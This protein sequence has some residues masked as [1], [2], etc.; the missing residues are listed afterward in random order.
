MYA[1]G[2]STVSLVQQYG[3]LGRCLRAKVPLNLKHDVA[4]GSLQKFAGGDAVAPL[5]NDPDGDELDEAWNPRNKALADHKFKADISTWGYQDQIGAAATILC[6]T[7][8]R[9]MA[10]W[11]YFWGTAI[12]NDKG[13]PVTNADISD[14]TSV[15]RFSVCTSPAIPLV[16]NLSFI[17]T[18][19]TLTVA[20]NFDPGCTVGLN[21][22]AFKLTVR[23]HNNIQTHTVDPDAVSPPCTIG[24]NQII[25]C[26]YVAPALNILRWIEIKIEPKQHRYGPP[27]YPVRVR[28]YS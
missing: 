4:Y 25:A 28:T 2:W 3:L 1:G 27:A 15:Y 16:S 20:W 13:W 19:S 6:R 22:V 5:G 9:N 7:N 26:S 18:G 8:K 10:E 23:S 12:I 21:D 17:R 11:V 14:F 24:A